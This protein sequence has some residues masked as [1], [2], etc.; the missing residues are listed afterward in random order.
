MPALGFR[1]AAAVFGA[2]LVRPAAL[3]HD[4]VVPVGQWL[5]LSWNAPLDGAL[6]VRDNLVGQD[7]LF[8]APERLDFRLAEDSPAY[9]LGFEPIPFEE[10]GLYADAY[11]PASNL[12]GSRVGR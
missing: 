4:A 11:R 10:I 12:T 9:P 7:P 3:S 6:E 2:A 1:V 5:D 8:L